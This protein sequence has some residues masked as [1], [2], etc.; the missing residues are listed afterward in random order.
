[1]VLNFIGTAHPPPG[2]TPQHDADLTRAEIATTN[3]G[4]RGGTEVLVEHDA[5]GGAV[6]RVTSSWEGRDGS[7]RVSGVIHDDDAA[8]AVRAST[9]RGARGTRRKS[10]LILS[11]CR[12]NRC[13]THYFLRGT[14]TPPSSRSVRKFSH[15]RR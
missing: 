11:C 7:L 5:R 15:V 2:P 6:G 12:Y 3:L 8:R 4:L 13:Y 10:V 1:M 9:S 14:Q